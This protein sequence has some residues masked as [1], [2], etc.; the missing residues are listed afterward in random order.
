MLHYHPF[1]ADSVAH[2]VP[3][4]TAIADNGSFHKHHD[5]HSDT[6]YASDLAYH[7]EHVVLL[8]DGSLLV[9]YVL[10][11]D[12]GPYTCTVHNS[13][14]RAEAKLTVTLDYN[15]LFEVK[16]MSLVVGMVCAAT[17]FALN[18]VYVIIMWVARKLVNKRRRERINKI[19]VSIDDYRATQISRIRAN[20][21]NQIGRI[22]DHY[23]VQST[24]LRDNYNTQLKR[25]QR[26]KRGC[27]NQVERIRDNYHTRMAHLKDYTSHQ[28]QQI[29]DA[30][31]NQ[32]VRIRDYGS[33]QM[34]RLRETYKHQSKHVMKVME[35]MNLDN[36]RN[37]MEAE[38]MRTDSMML[39]INFPDFPEVEEDDDVGE[40]DTDA[41]SLDV[42]S[43]TEDSLYATAFNT[44]ASSQESLETLMA[45]VQDITV[46]I[47]PF[48]YSLSP[49][50]SPPY[51]LTEI[52]VPE[53]DQ[54][55]DPPTHSAP[56]LSVSSPAHSTASTTQDDAYCTPHTSPM[57]TKASQ[58]Q[59]AALTNAAVAQ[60]PTQ[61]PAQPAYQDDNFA[62]IVPSPTLTLPPEGSFVLGEVEVIPS[63]TPCETDS[64]GMVINIRESVV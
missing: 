42:G 8:S 58:T 12:A 54:E 29:R 21:S 41:G 1:N 9:D 44:D 33:L 31:N 3:A 10:R 20:Y 18:A 32:V 13:Q 26:V 15:I 64:E 34:E 14:Y 2:L 27:S 30:T 50:P 59:I 36:C 63:D 17:F 49:T 38:C 48:S 37:V 22:R 24:K 57:R 60:A 51:V 11:S 35:S 43:Q 4:H 56:T 40:E 61:P 6:G 16:V 46:E 45:R 53:P 39:D 47:L 62:H 7:P 28:I 25:V 52:H 5:W 55:E 23:H 19:L